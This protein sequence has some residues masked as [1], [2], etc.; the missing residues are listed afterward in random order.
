MARKAITKA[1][2]TSA[3]GPSAI[4]VGLRG[5]PGGSEEEFSLVRGSAQLLGHRT[6]GPME[7]VVRPM[8]CPGIKGNS[9]LEN[10][11]VYG[12][13]SFLFF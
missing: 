11:G 8:E 13:F 1:A 2:G 6:R 3:D 12:F 7:H 10:M 5:R 4:G 9:E